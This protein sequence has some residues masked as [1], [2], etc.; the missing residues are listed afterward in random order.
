[1][2]DRAPLERA[3]TV[4]VS[5]LCAI[6]ALPVLLLGAIAYRVWEG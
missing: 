6:A 1:M 5:S 3:L 4:I 2:N